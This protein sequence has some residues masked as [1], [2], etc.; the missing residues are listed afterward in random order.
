[1]AIRLRFSTLARPPL[2][3]CGL[4]Q[5]LEVENLADFRGS[6]RIC[7]PL[8]NHSAIGPEELG[9]ALVASFAL[10]STPCG[11]SPRLNWSLAVQRASL[12]AARLSIND[13]WRAAQLP[14]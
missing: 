4:F 5:R 1:M 12:T 9:G 3:V 7:S 13:G 10:G 2:A 14:I 11:R 6:A 8:R